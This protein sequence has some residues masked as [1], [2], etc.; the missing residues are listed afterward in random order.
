MQA[1]VSGAT[2]VPPF[3]QLGRHIA[4][5]VHG[6]NSALAMFELYSRVSHRC[7]VHCDVQAHVSG[8]EQVPPFIHIG[9]H[10]ARFQGKSAHSLPSSLLSANNKPPLPVLSTISE[11]KL[12]ICCISEAMVNC[13]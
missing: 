1:H 12:I 6:C 9:L 3:R 8:A 10:I 13:C 11:D 7:P 4:G 2:Q 5:L